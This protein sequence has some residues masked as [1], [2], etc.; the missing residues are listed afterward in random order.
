MDLTF[1]KIKRNNQED[2]ERRQR[3]TGWG[4]S[5]GDVRTVTERSRGVWCHTGS[6]V[7]GRKDWGA[8]EHTGK[9]SLW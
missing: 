2:V 1:K 5:S 8:R 6:T 7:S 3:R 4:A 9:L